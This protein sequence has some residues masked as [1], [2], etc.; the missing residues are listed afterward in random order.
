MS[1]G[2]S[3]RRQN[4]AFMTITP[5]VVSHRA[6]H[7]ASHPMHY[8]RIVL[9]VVSAVALELGTFATISMLITGR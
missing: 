7:S 3:L 2:Q 4:Y 1:A 8:M 5:P 6:S 9:A